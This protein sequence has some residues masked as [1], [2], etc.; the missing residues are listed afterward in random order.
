MTEEHIHLKNHNTQTQPKDRKWEPLSIDDLK[1]S[2]KKITSE[3]GKVVI[4]LFSDTFS[5]QNISTLVKMQQQGGGLVSCA[6]NSLEP[7]SE[8]EDTQNRH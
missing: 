1:F 2:I 5:N 6:M 4:T 3:Q 8:P 7:E